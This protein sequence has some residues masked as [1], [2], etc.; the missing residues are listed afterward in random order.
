MALSGINGHVDEFKFSFYGPSDDHSTLA[1]KAL[2]IRT[3]EGSLS[4]LTTA[5]AWLLLAYCLMKLTA[6]YVQIV[7]ILIYTVYL[8]SD[9]QPRHTHTS[10][11]TH[12]DN[13]SL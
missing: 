7:L 5:S 4:G 9:E 2:E 6:F 8:F 11:N 1:S 10:P 13:T 12:T 3:W